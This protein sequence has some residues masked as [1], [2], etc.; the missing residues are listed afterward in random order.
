MVS[1]GDWVQDK[2][3]RSV[4]GNNWAWCCQICLVE[5]GGASE[6]RNQW[7]EV[8]FRQLDSRISIDC[9]LLD[10]KK[11]PDSVKKI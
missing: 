4:S 8:K 11:L 6:G 1:S 9:G 3:L 2:P 5:A 10:L 7:G